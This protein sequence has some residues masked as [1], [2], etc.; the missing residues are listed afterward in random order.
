MRIKKG[1]GDRTEG[2]REREQQER[3][4]ERERQGETARS[5]VLHCVLRLK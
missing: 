2:T 3:E 1:W 5:I 4:R